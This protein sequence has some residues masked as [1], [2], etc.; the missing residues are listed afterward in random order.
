[1]SSEA[2]EIAKT[3]CVQDMVEG[4]EDD[5]VRLLHHLERTSVEFDG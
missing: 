4:F 1:M 5:L 3:L 2:A